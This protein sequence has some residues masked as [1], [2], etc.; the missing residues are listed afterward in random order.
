MD[1]E[2]KFAV[3]LRDVLAYDLCGVRDGKGARHAPR[4]MIINDP[5]GELAAIS[6]GNQIRLGKAAY[7]INPLRAA[8]PRGQ[9]WVRVVRETVPERYAHWPQRQSGEWS[10]PDGYRPS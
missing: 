8:R 3:K 10:Y 7:C 1:T 4:R 2:Q 5:R 6:I 9:K